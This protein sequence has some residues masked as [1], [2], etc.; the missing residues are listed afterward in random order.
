MRFKQTGPRKY[1]A[2]AGAAPRRRGVPSRF[3]SR[4]Q[5]LRAGCCS[6][7]GAAPG[8]RRA[9][10]GRLAGCLVARP[11]LKPSERGGSR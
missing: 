8:T 10:P 11:L 7:A 2:R 9:V 4:V 3:Y 1:T 5:G 6:P